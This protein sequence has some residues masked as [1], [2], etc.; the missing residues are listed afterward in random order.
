MK[1]IFLDIDGVMNNQQRGSLKFEQ[2]AIVALNYITD[3]TKAQIVVSSDWRHYFSVQ[4]LRLLFDSH[5]I[6]GCVRETTPNKESRSLEIKECVSWAPSPESYICLDDMK[7]EGHPQILVDG[8]TGLTIQNAY[9]AV[10]ILNEK[11]SSE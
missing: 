3:E 8:R 4:G 10:E 6:T 1:F 9:D 2:E 5:G 11:V 7:L